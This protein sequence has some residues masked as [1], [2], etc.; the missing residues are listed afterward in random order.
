MP[1]H[2]YANA[3]TVVD[4]LFILQGAIVPSILSLVANF[5]SARRSLHG[6]RFDFALELEFVHW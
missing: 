5:N 3:R 2:T 4:L 1:T 6:A